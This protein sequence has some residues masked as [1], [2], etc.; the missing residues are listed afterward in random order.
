MAFLFRMSIAILVISSTSS[1]NADC[2]RAAERVHFDSARYEVGPF[3][4]RLARERGEP[5]SRPPAD[6]IDGYLTKPDGPG[7]FAAIVLLHGCSGLPDQFKAGKIKGLWSERL[8]AWGYVVLA[9][10]SFTTRG[11]SNTCLGE[12]APRDADAFGALTY[13]AR[14]PFID[15]NHIAVIGFSAGGIA[16]LS[17][18]AQRDF[19][20]F[21]GEREFKAAIAFYPLCK[22]YDPMAIPTLVLAGEADDWLPASTCK[23]MV[24]RQTS[25][26]AS[27]RLVVYPGAYHGFD[28]PGPSRTY[29]GHHLEYNASAAELASEEVRRFLAEQLGR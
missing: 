16:T 21:E 13:L 27:A 12:P 25:S 22:P 8:A 18:A 4:L 2:A 28:G 5:I 7:P 24:K 11:I 15:P 6:T 26:G 1:L 10:D 14:Q 29:F 20:L 17:V 9:P 19:A 23:A 3:Q